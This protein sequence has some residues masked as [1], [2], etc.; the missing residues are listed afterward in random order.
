MVSFKIKRSFFF[1][2]GIICFI[3]QGLYASPAVILDKEYQILGPSLEILEDKENS[4][5]IEQ[6]R[7]PEYANKFFRSNSQ[8]PNL[9]YTNSAFWVRFTLNRPTVE[10]LN[11]KQWLLQVRRSMIHT[12]NVYIPDEKGSLVKHLSG[13][14]QPFSSRYMANRFFL[15]PL[16]ISPGETKT[17]Y[18]YYKDKGASLLP[19]SVIT[20][21]KQIQS[22]QFEYIVFGFLSGLRLLLIIYNFLFFITVRDKNFLYY[23]LL[24]IAASIYYLAITGLAN[25]YVWPNAV[26]FM[27]QFRSFWG[28]TAVVLS[29]IFSTT[30]L[31]LKEDL[32]VMNRFF[33]LYLAILMLLAI[34]SFF[35]SNVYIIP[36]SFILIIVQYI[37][38]VIVAIKQYSNGYR[39]AR[40]YIVGFSF[41]ILGLL[42][43]FLNRMDIIPLNFITENGQQ[44]MDLFQAT[45]LSYAVAD[46]L[47]IV[48]KKH[49]A[50]Q[51]E[52]I[53]NLKQFDA[54]KNEFLANTS[55][56]LRTPLHGIIGL[57]DSLVRHNRDILSAGSLRDLELISSS[58]RRLS[59]MVNDIQDFSRIKNNEINLNLKPVDI[60]S[61]SDTV[62]S[63]SAP[64]AEGKAIELSS[65]IV[66]TMPNIY[67]DEDRIKQVMH[68][69][70]GNA[71]KF[72][73]SGGVHISATIRHADKTQPGSKAFAA[74]CVSDTGIGI[75]EEYHES[76]FQS[77][78]QADGTSSRLYGGTGLGL[79]I[80]KKLVDLHGGEITVQ[81]EPGA[82]SAFTFTVPLAFDSD[83]SMKKKN[84]IK[85]E[86]K[87]PQENNK[88]DN[89]S[90]ISSAA[91]EETI[92]GNPSILLVDDDP[93]NIRILNDF[94]TGQECSIQHAYNG[95]DALDIIEKNNDRKN[96]INLVLLDVMMP[97]MSG[98][99]VCSR[100]RNKYSLS[101]LAVI[102]L[103]AKVEQ[104]DISRGFES[105]ANDYIVKPFNTWELIR[106]INNITQAENDPLSFSCKD[107]Y[108]D[109]FFLC[110]D[111]VYLSSQGK[112]TIFHT[113]NQDITV[114][115]QFKTI[116]S[117]L[118]D[119][120]IRIHK[121]HIINS[122]YATKLSH[123]GSG[124]YHLLL[125]DEDETKLVVSPLYA[126]AIK[127]KIKK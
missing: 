69:L 108:N 1:I 55:H 56:E 105:G 64:I 58:G 16:N 9:G 79:A 44:M 43:Y 31:N 77:F 22:N 112:T 111:I 123:I 28:N 86:N 88:G 35:I 18:L 40:F 92:Q 106:R 3:N 30:F 117:Q 63:L 85:N 53:N 102:M 23:T 126:A 50:A 34:A 37:L 75:P 52:S 82:G 48:E 120:F 2:F 94:F 104:E 83:F 78:E 122:S 57:S 125:S 20:K 110:K 72:T 84:E 33:N 36:V 26:P 45:A 103:T 5:T 7:S 91:P 114:S 109:Y 54:L 14:S 6:V 89:T 24:T 97:H 29:I 19:I 66:P 15:F 46:R 67:A 118:P 119:N 61:I 41:V 65:S 47:R 107:K 90:I 13:E 87:Q 115:I 73:V 4:F 124:R 8:V 27:S 68:N 127:E 96:D 116:E 12:L 60:N 71:V 51:Q 42:V 10:A 59:S 81:S 74:V 32:P 11:G 76:I 101:E 62:I 38:F 95:I 100:I 93:V 70:V 121:Q 113:T 80:S 49:Y 21:D 39:A 99:E 17:L 98:Y 25:Q